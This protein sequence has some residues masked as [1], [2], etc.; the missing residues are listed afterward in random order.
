[1]PS[2]PSL[3][4]DA[5]T[6]LALSLIGAA[7]V[8]GFLVAP[9]PGPIIVASGAKRWKI[10]KNI[11]KWWKLKSVNLSHSLAVSLFAGAVEPAVEA[12]A[13]LRAVNAS[14]VFLAYARGSLQ[15]VSPVVRASRKALVYLLIDLV[16]SF[17][18]PAG[19]TVAFTRN[20]GAMSAAGWV[21]AVACVKRLRFYV[22]SFVWRRLI[23]TVIKSNLL[24]L[25]VLKRFEL[26]YPSGK[27]YHACAKWLDRDVRAT[28]FV[29]FVYLYSVVGWKENFFLRFGLIDGF[30]RKILGL[31]G[32]T[33]NI[34]ELSHPGM[35][36]SFPYLLLIVIVNILRID[37]WSF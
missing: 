13:R 33:R 5:G 14:P 15:I 30:F 17:S 20:A 7:H 27:R 29:W 9:W 28:V 31:Q 36:R 16:A 34:A 24:S 35:I 23:S 6:V 3:A 22:G 26:V 37:N 21:R 19:F 2:V 1:M 11:Y 32:S 4:A 25:W 18:L 12:A 10:I 8:A